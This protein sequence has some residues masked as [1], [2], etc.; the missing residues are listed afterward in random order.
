MFLSISSTS[1]CMPSAIAA[2]CIVF[3][4][5]GVPAAL[6]FAGGGL[7]FVIGVSLV[8]F[9][10]FYVGLI[11]GES[12]ANRLIIS[13]FWAMWAPNLP[14]TVIGLTGLWR[15]RPAPSAI[16]LPVRL[17][18][19][20]TTPRRLPGGRRPAG[21]CGYNKG[22]RMGAR[23][24]ELADAHALGACAL[25]RVGSNPTPG[26]KKLGPSPSPSLRVRI[27]PAGSRSPRRVSLTP[28]K[29][30]KFESHS[31]HQSQRPTRIKP[32]Q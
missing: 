18:R 30:L 14:F 5:I 20:L 6:Q 31:W 16:L 11:G 4:L 17:P 15:L 24:A 2:A 28:A 32:P 13:P 22:G 9:T 27:S 25:R 29:R 3:V 21:N 23:M 19:W 26:T 7:G 8:V 12:L 1:A 10:V